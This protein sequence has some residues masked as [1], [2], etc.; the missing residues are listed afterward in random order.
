MSRV[1][2]AQARPSDSCSL[3]N[4]DGKAH[5]LAEFT[6]PRRLTP[7]VFGS[8]Q[9]WRLGR[10]GTGS[11]PE[12]GSLKLVEEVEHHWGSKTRYAVVTGSILGVVVI[13][14]YGA[15]RAIVV[16]DATWVDVC[17]TG[18]ARLKRRRG[19]GALIAVVIDAKVDA[20]VPVVE[21]VAH[22][23]LPAALDVIDAVNHNRGRCIPSVTVF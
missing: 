1:K 19:I 12:F 22:F 13:A 18:A 21:A 7:N 23:S 14:E 5:S 11:L 17:G 8:T 6:E 10:P 15:R 2:K 16:F 3:A 20:T 9:D 4:R